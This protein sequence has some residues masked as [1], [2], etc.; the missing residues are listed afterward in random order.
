MSRHQKYIV[1]KDRKRAAATLGVLSQMSSFA[2]TSQYSQSLAAKYI[3]VLIHSHLLKTLLTEESTTLY[4]LPLCLF[5]A[6]GAL[7]ICC[8]EIESVHKYMRLLQY[9][10]EV[11]C[12]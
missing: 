11:F 6:F 3:Y 5:P 7:G 2:Y 9:E 8:R 12:V 1:V 4:A 10:D